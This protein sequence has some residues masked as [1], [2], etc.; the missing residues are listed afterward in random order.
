MWRTQRRS[1]GASSGVEVHLIICHQVL[2]Q[3][4]IM[5]QLTIYVRILICS[6]RCAPSSVPSRRT[7]A[8]RDDVGVVCQAMLYLVARSNKMFFLA[9]TRERSDALYSPICLPVLRCAPFRGDSG[10]AECSTRRSL[11]H[12]TRRQKLWKHVVSDMPPA[13]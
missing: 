4:C 7:G 6:L 11:R 9:R 1:G 2:F 5:I 8:E 10:W 12:H 13:A 3:C